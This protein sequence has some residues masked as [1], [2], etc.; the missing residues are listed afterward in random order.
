MLT[1]WSIWAGIV[2][3]TDQSDCSMPPSHVINLVILGYTLVMVGYTQLYMV[4]GGYAWLYLH[5]YAWLYLVMLG[6]TW[7]CLVIPGY[8]W[9]YLVMLGY[10]WL[11]LVIPGYAW[12]YLVMYRLHHEGEVST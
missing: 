8:A 10:T 12:L 4:I 2:P 9:L 3:P 7:L 1:V 6:Y 5:G 11:C